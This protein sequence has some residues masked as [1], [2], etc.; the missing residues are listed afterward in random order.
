MPAATVPW[1]KMNR[2]THFSRTRSSM[3]QI[4]QA[5]HQFRADKRW[6]LLL[7]SGV[8]LAVETVDAERQHQLKKSLNKLTEENCKMLSNMKR[9]SKLGKPQ[10]L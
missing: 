4:I 2:E 10:S 5:D 1:G 8:R 3:Y 7:Q 6:E 9:P